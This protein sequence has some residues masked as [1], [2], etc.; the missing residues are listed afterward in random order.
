MMTE[1][2]EGMKLRSHASG[3]RCVQMIT[4]NRRK[5]LGH[6]LVRLFVRSHRSL[7]RWLRSAR[8]ACALCCAHTFSRSLTS[9]TPELVG[10]E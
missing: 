4:R 5:V 9:L 3:D 7:I 1:A 8:F 2:Y 6:S 10:S